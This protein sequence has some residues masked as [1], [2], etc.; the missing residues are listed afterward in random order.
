MSQLQ[1]GDVVNVVGRAV[2]RVEDA[3]H[4]WHVYRIGSVVL[5]GEIVIAQTRQVQIVSIV[6]AVARGQDVPG[7]NQAAAA[8]P[9]GFTSFLVFVAQS[10]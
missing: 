6:D 9:L 3:L 10:G 2:A 7:G 8:Q 1:Y 4:D 5:A